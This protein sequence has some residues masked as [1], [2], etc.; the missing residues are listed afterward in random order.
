MRV[1]FTE[2]RHLTAQ[3]KGAQDEQ[4][5]RAQRILRRLR[6]ENTRKY[7]PGGYS[8]RAKGCTC[9]QVDNHYGVGYRGQAG[10]YVTSESCPLH[11]W[12]TQTGKLA[13]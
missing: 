10:R 12:T 8:A 7:P 1:I 9:A 5:W 11:G 6:E 2:V 13:G 3:E 4:C